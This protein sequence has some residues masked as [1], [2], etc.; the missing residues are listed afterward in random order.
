MDICSHRVLR[1][2]MEGGGRHDQ[3]ILPR[4]FGSVQL[5]RQPE[6]E[7]RVTAEGAAQRPALLLE[8]LL[9]TG[10]CLRAL[11]SSV[12]TTIFAAF[13]TLPGP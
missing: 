12:F 9:A 5:H 7:T 13:R 8:A 10:C 3:D 4:G 1:T 6:E 2:E 11:F